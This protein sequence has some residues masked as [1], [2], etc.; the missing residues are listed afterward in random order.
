MSMVRRQTTLEKL[1][2]KK[3]NK[4]WFHVWDFLTLKECTLFV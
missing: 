3:Q 1:Q 2:K 4:L